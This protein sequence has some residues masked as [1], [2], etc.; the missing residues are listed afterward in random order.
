MVT[1]AKGSPL[2]DAIPRRTPLDAEG[3]FTVVAVSR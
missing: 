2:G 1:D 3:P